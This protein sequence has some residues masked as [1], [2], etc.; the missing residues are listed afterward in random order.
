MN[1]S[2]NTIL[3]QF[4]HVAHGKIQSHIHMSYI[5]HITYVH[6]CA[7]IYLSFSNMIYILNVPELDTHSHSHLFLGM[8][9]EP[10]EIK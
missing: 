7:Y 2:H 4:I 6:K 1:L 8:P 9:V 10:Y 5:T 3:N